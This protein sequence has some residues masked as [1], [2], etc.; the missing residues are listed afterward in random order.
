MR[1]YK[2]VLLLSIMMEGWN[3]Q[4]AIILMKKRAGLMFVKQTPQVQQQIRRFFRQL[5]QYR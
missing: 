5:H 2:Y 3:R 4:S 1:A